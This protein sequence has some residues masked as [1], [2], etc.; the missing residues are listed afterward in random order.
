MLKTE[1]R[2]ERVLLIGVIIGSKTEA[3]VEENLAELELLVKTAGGKVIDSM[4]QKRAV[5]HKGLYVGKGKADEI[6]AMIDMLDID[7]VV[8][9][10][11]LTAAQTK[12]L[13]SIFEETKLID[14]SQVILDI[15]AKHARTKEAKTQV[16][17]ALLQYQLPR[18]T[19]QWTHLERQRGGIG[20]R[21]GMGETQIEIDRRLIRDKIAKNK[22]ELKKI[23]EQRNTRRKNRDD[24]FKIALVGYTNAGKSSLMNLFSDADVLVEDKLFATLDTTIRNIQVQGYE[25]L[26][27]DTVGFIRKLPHGLVASFRSTLQ[28]VLDADLI[29]KVIDVSSLNYSAHIDTV[30]EVLLEI[31]AKDRAE[32]VI[33]NKIDLV[34]DASVLKNILKQNPHAIPISVTQQVNILELE[35][36]IMEA[37]KEKYI[38][39][40]LTLK[41][42]QQKLLANLHEAT[43]VL[44]I[45][46]TDDGI[47]VKIKSR[48]TTFD[49]FKAQTLK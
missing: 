29:L 5:A 21:G 31:D 20:T 36:K 47:L 46:Y 38:E 17:L 23:A 35:N 18:L 39:G 26:I 27:S 33:F 43:E 30:N 10:D 24:I 14:R 22:E 1:A 41:Y 8:F 4:T 37:V 40:T 16:E 45:E 2:I 13:Q 44:N 15:F 42:D 49:H 34:E 28:E 11:E 3:E 19:R 25:L 32:V 48:R 6:K 9:D 12:N 7:V